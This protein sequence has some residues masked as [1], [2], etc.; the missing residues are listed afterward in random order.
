[1]PTGK[2]GTCPWVRMNRRSAPEQ[3]GS[4]SSSGLVSDGT[5]R[6]ASACVPVANR[7]FRKLPSAG[8]R[9]Q[10]RSAIISDCSV[11]GGGPLHSMACRC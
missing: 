6:I 10:T 5:R 9:G 4:R 8:V 1:M 3:S 11:W 2:P 7:T